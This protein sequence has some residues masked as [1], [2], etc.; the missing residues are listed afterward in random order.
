MGRYIVWQLHPTGGRYLCDILD[1]MEDAMYSKRTLE[2]DKYLR[3]TFEI[4]KKEA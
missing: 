4:E 2:R 1:N 3:G